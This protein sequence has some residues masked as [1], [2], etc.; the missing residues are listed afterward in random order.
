M[1]SI[2]FDSQKLEAI[3]R[4]FNLKLIILHGSRSSGNLVHSESDLDIAVV[5]VTTRPLDEL[6]LIADLSELFGESRIDVVD[7]TY[8]NPLLNMAVARHS[9]LLSGLNSDFDYFLHKAYFR[10]GDYLPYLKME[11]ELTKIK[12]DQY[13]SY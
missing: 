13:V 10:Y 6:S 12:L 1:A 7:V 3:R 11:S 5:R 2:A 4:K 8:G 9:R